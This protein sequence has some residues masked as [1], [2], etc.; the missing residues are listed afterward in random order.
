MAGCR[1]EPRVAAPA[2]SVA[3]EFGPVVARVGED[4]IYAAEVKAQ[5]ERD[6]TS[7]RQA[8]DDLI[9]FHLLAQR[10]RGAVPTP[11]GVQKSASVQRLVERELEPQLTPE[12]IPESELRALYQRGFSRYVHGRLVEV[13]VLAVFTGARMKPEPRARARAT[14]LALAEH[15]AARPIRTAQDFETV[16]N[17]PAWRGR[18]VQFQQTLQA[19]EQPFPRAVGASVAKLRAPGDTT[20]L[21]EDETGYYIARYVSE[22]PPR[23]TSFAEAAPE[24]RTLYHPHWRQRRFAEFAASLEVKHGAA[25]VASAAPAPRR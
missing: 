18:K 2:P 9:R 13:A 12:A 16:A 11:D 10:A 25:R 22:K 6:G 17:D 19:D 24:L 8:V 14:A 23:N 5:A 4:A 1:G 21:I 3:H 15:V 7:A 20:P